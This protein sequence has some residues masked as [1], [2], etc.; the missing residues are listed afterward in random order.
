MKLQHIFLL[1]I[2]GTLLT[3]CHIF[4]NYERPT[5]VDSLA[6]TI[7]YRDILSQDSV[8]FGNTPWQ[9]VFTDPTLQSH[10]NCVLE[11]N[12]DMRSADLNLQK[13]EIGLKLSKYQFFLPS[14]SFSP[15]GTISKVFDMDMENSKTYS[16][17]VA[18]SWQIDAFGKLRNSK[19]QVEMQLLEVKETHQAIQTSLVCATAQL[20]YGLQVLDEQLHIT[21]S[22]LQL[23][24]K[25]IQALEAMK[26]AGM[27]N[28]AAVSSAKAQYI[29]IQATLP[30][31]ESSIT[32]ME[33]S[34]CLLRH[35]APHAIERSAFTPDA[36]RMDLRTGIPFQLLGQ[37]PDVRIAELELA[38]CFYAKL[39]ARSAFYPA[40]T[41]TGNGAFT[42]SLGSAVV[43]PG[44]FIA[45][46]IA[47]L[48]QPIVQRGQLIGQLKVAK[49]AEQQAELAFEKALLNAATEVSNDVASYHSYAQQLTL[50]KQQVAELQRANDATHELFH[51]GGGTTTYLETLTAEMGLLQGQLTLI[52]D[53]Y[54]MILSGI[55]LY[56]A[57]GG[58]R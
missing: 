30:A 34:L 21:Q 16:F 37:R 57:L 28:Q 29:Q 46:G 8:N 49:L 36:F 18:A 3:S 32:Q 55:N 26:Q 41:I 23:W 14:I 52:N 51:H 17:P 56:Q 13:S 25:N 5:Q 54:Q 19:K 43:N 1:F 4:G 27:V 50:T 7:Q 11:Q 33:N 47:S 10:I 53:Q 58:G 35:E 42:N 44:K 38:R 48:V 9:E 6:Q 2:S 39:G 45:S 40:L 20:Y 12:T 24:D 15:S 31:L 22:T